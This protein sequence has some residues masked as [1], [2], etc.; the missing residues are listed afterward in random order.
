MTCTRR[1]ASASLAVSP[2]IVSLE[3]EVDMSSSPPIRQ[4]LRQA[5]EDG[6]RDIVL[7]I[8]NVT[9]MDAAA[10]GMLVGAHRLFTSGGGTLRLSGPQGS[11]RRVLEITGL[12]RLLL[13]EQSHVRTEGRPS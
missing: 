10:L 2:L 9:F 12:D 4:A 11:I 8:R 1:S 5:F 3:G 6:A 7:D 13:G